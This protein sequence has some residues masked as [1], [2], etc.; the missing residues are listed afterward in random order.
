M[1]ATVAAHSGPFDIVFADPPYDLRDFDRFAA[2]LAT[3][4]E[5]VAP[6]GL[7]VV[8]Y[9]AGCEL[10][11]LPEPSGTKRF[12]DTEIRIYEMPR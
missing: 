9:R 12:G 10:P 1:W 6:E 8:Q 11:G 7:V 5:G 3:A 4:R 2:R